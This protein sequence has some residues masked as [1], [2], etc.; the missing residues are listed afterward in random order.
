MNF[1]QLLPAATLFISVTPNSDELRSYLLK[2][3]GEQAVYPEKL[4]I[5]QRRKAT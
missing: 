2:K 1:T 5:V 4:E 3:N